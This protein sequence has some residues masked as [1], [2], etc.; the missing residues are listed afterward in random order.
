M[1][2]FFF[3]NKYLHDHHNSFGPVFFFHLIVSGL[4]RCVFCFPNYWEG[5]LNKG[6]R[7]GITSVL[8]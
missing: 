8:T 6:I 5:S 4:A 2:I 1:Y 7:A 3:Q